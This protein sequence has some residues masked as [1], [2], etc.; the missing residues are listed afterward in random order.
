VCSVRWNLY[1]YVMV[2]FT[3]ASREC[4]IVQAASCRLLTAE[5]CVQPWVNS[6]RSV[7]K[8]VAP[9]QG[10]LRAQCP[11]TYLTH[12]YSF[13]L[14]SY[15]KKERAKLVR[16]SD[17]I[18]QKVFI[19]FFTFSV[20][21][22]VKGTEWSPSTDCG[23]RKC[24]DFGSNSTE[25]AGLSVYKSIIVYFKDLYCE[26]VKTISIFHRPES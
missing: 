22:E 11:S 16:K 14:Y 10:F 6:L 25:Y 15:Q 9:E 4:E 13:T 24:K 1:F 12:S 23:K 26:G 2:L 17:S 18:V 7:E 21:L 3:W 8:K 5:A 20:S 19:L